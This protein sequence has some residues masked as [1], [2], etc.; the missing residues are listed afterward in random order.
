MSTTTER[1][2]GAI[3]DIS[4]FNLLKPF[5][6]QSLLQAV[7]TALPSRDSIDAQAEHGDEAV[8]WGAFRTNGS[9][10]SLSAR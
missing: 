9:N 2:P 5:D 4:R 1:T 8:F 7:R 3:T 6:R 10:V